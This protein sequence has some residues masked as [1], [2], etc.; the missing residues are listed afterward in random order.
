MA[1][2]R[3]SLNC[4]RHFYLFTCFRSATHSLNGSILIVMGGGGVVGVLEISLE[5]KTEFHQHMT[6]IHELNNK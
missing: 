1:T 3:K 2:S 4:L 5:I 6:L